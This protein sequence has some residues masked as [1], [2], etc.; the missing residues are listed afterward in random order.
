MQHIT[1][2]CTEFRK[3]FMKPMAQLISAWVVHDLSHIAQISRVM[4]KCYRRG[5]WPMGGVSTDCFRLIGTMNPA[6]RGTGYTKITK[7]RQNKSVV[8]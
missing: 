6:K 5:C 3:H 8:K 1:L 2:L 7:E 4:V